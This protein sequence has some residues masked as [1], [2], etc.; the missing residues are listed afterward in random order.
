MAKK[1]MVVEGFGKYNMDEDVRFFQ[2]EEEAVKYAEDEA[3]IC[4]RDGREIKKLYVSLVD[5]DRIEENGWD[6]DE[7]VILDIA[8]RWY[9]VMQDNE[10]DDW[11][12]G[13]HI[14]TTAERMVDEYK[15]SGFEEAYIAVIDTHTGNA[16]CVEE[17]R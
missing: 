12:E 16:V 10:D 6:D 2:T 17:I 13:S 7:E 15:Q 14:L 4:E 1:F 5:E 11:S 8:N 9:A 3:Y